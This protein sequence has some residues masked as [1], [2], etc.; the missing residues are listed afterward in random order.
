LKL[1]NCWPFLLTL[2]VFCGCELDPVEQ[3]LIG[4]W[5]MVGLEHPQYPEYYN[6]TSGWG[7]DLFFQQGGVVEGWSYLFNK[8]VS[9]TQGRWWSSE[10]GSRLFYIQWTT[11]QK[12]VRVELNKA[13]DE[14]SFHYVSE[15]DGAECRL[16]LAKI[17]GGE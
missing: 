12:I 2:V 15:I 10:F 7:L 3:K 13:A 5:E 9:T 17:K 4:G 8:K 14:L 11:D 16:R 6:N 1:L